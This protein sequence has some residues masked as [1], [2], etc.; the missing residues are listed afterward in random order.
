M[1][2]KDRI[3]ESEAMESIEE[4]Y[5]YDKLTKQYLAIL[6]NGFVETI[7]NKSCEKGKFLEVGSGT[8]R[9][10][11][12]IA[13]NNR[14]ADI[15]GIDLSK[16]MIQVATE[17]SI[18]HSVSEQINF[19][20]GSATDIP[21]EDNSFDSVYCHN[22]LHHLPDPFLMIKEMKRVVK[23]EGSFFIRDLIRI[24]S[25]LIPFHVHL[26]G[27]TYNQLMKKEYRDSINAALSK[28][29]WKDIHSK[30]DIKNSKITYHFITHQGIE[31]EANNKRQDYIKVPTPFYLNLFKNMYV[32]KY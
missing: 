19:K 2:I 5:A 13:K 28:E 16:N 6:H 1:K 9:V 12:G 4:V 8:G 17:N 31:K 11:I 30:A 21:F 23:P 22:M 14:Y 32:S 7:L 10:S 3:L 20:F 15:T 24:P 26:L 27:L 18:N 29:E 25:A